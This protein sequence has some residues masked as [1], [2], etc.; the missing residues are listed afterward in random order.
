MT[1][2]LSWNV[3]GIRAAIRNGLLQVLA[4]HQP[5]LV[6][7]QEIKISADDLASVA[8]QFTDYHLDASHARKAGYS[9]VALLSRKS[10]NSKPPLVCTQLDSPASLFSDEGRILIAKFKDFTLYNLY[11]PSGTSGEERQTLKYE[12]LELLLAHLAALPVAERS[13][14]VVCGDFNICHQPID[15]HHP[16][17]AERRRLTGFLPEERAWMDRFVALGFVD[18]YRHLHPNTAE[19]YS[20]WTYRAGARKKNLGWRIDYQFVASALAPRIKRAELL[21]TTLGSDHCPTL[22]EID[23]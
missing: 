9:G 2:I 12:F 21:T 1:L 18:S 3:N 11:F 6:C 23:L 8:I 22:L 16:R 4:E 10:S 19:H 17:E 7:L 15:I 13:R 14:L 20:W 5:D